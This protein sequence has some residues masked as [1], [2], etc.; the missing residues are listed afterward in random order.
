M[1]ISYLFRC[2]FASVF[3][4]F[5][6]FLFAFFVTAFYVV[7]VSFSISAFFF[8]LSP[9]KKIFFS[10]Y[11]IS[12]PKVSQYFLYEEF[13]LCN[14]QNL[15]R[16]W[17]FR[18]HNFAYRKYAFPV[19]IH[20]LLFFIYRKRVSTQ[21]NTL[22]IMLFIYSKICEIIFSTSSFSYGLVINSDAPY[23]TA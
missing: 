23:L 11:D 10:I 19:W 16:F 3:S 13:K 1:C 4:F 9:K 2:Y 14:T 22:L 5:F 12:S 6:S 15:P 17:T 7:L 20:L 21:V 18:F 8:I